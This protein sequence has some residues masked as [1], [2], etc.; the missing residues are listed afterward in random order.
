[1]GQERQVVTMGDVKFDDVETQVAPTAPAPGA[2]A[3]AWS[4]CAEDTPPDRY[5]WRVTWLNAGGIAVCGVVLAVALGFGV[6]A[7]QQG[8]RDEHMPD[9]VVSAPT[10]SIPPES[11]ATMPP[12]PTPEIAPPDTG[13]APA[14]PPAPGTFAATPMRDD[15]RAFFAS[16]NRDRFPY[17]AG[18]ENNAIAAASNVCQMV[19]QGYDLGYV[20][21]RMTPPH[22]PY[23]QRQAELFV[24]DALAAYCPHAGMEN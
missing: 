3:S 2:T 4:E 16:L 17:R 15:D 9:V 22:A 14:P 6:W 19:R 21:S 8:Q 11:Q 7:W 1:V 13:T 23:T 18:T 24:A 5:S 10:T 12:Q 20:E